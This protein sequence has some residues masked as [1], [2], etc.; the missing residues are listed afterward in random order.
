MAKCQLDWDWGYPVNISE[1]EHLWMEGGIVG[2]MTKT[3]SGSMVQY[4]TY[5][6]SDNFSTTEL[7]KSIRVHRDPGT[8]ISYCY[9]LTVGNVSRVL[10]LKSQLGD[11]II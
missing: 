11:N 10:K 3:D 5:N 1:S 6:F 7:I 9:Y 2:W 8:N 4:R